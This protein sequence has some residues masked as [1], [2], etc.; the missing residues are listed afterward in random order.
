M[1]FDT[2]EAAKTLENLSPDE[3]DALPFGVV[4]LSDTGVVTLFSKTEAQQSGFGER[5]AVGRS[6]FDLIA[7]C[8][9]TPAFRGRIDEQVRSGKLDLE[10][11]HT[12]DFS[13][14]ARFI[15]IRVCSAAG[16][17]FWLLLQR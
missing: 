16:G 1:T 8:M 4:R 9:N 6:F 11:G 3:I 14:P 5:R 17:G 2:P 15:R 7:P 12:G 13:D 10:F